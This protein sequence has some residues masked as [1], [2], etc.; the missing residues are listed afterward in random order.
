MRLSISLSED[1][2]MVVEGKSGRKV[3]IQDCR[4]YD[5]PKGTLINDVITDEEAFKDVLKKIRNQ[6]PSYAGK[7]HLTFGSNRV[8]TKV[9]QVPQM[10]QK[11]LLY[12]VEK[13]LESYLVEEKEMIYDYSLV[14]RSPRDGTGNMIL[15]AAMEKEKANRYKDILQE[16]GMRIVS[17]DIGLNA[18]LQLAER[19]PALEG[20]TFIL[21]VLDGRSMQT[22]LYIRGIYRHTGRSRFLYE[23][24][25]KE[26]IGEVIKD[27]NIINSFAKS[28]EEIQVAAV[29]FCG[30]QEEERRLLFRGVK[31]AMGMEGRELEAP[32]LFQIRRGLPYRLSDFA[33]ATGSLVGR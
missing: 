8:I 27:I 11:Q 33:Y 18:L 13:E 26:L 5:L 10:K 1:A 16:C 29:Y 20:G 15:A 17:M 3:R 32:E 23:R 9:M 4:R 21:A 6:Y 14:R 25:T 19:I 22:S 12:M 2:V 28:L 24:G 30:V 7:I 31:D